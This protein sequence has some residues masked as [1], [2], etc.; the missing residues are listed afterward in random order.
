MILHCPQSK[1][2]I[3]DFFSRCRF[4]AAIVFSLVAASYRPSVTS[5]PLIHRPYP[6]LYRGPYR[7]L[8]IRPGGTGGAWSYR[9]YRDLCPCRD[10]YHDPYPYHDPDPY[11]CLSPGRDPDLGR[12]P[13][14]GH[15]NP[16]SSILR[17]RDLGPVA[18]L[19]RRCESI[20]C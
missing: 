18:A 16:C 17:T 8:A 12:G 5:S 10:L 9:P 4:P 14:G 11:L 19:G 1:I 7:D 13:T 6:D 20:Q 15:R 2:H 3:L